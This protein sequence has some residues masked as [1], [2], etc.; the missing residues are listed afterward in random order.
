MPSAVDI[1]AVFAAVLR[2]LSDT[3]AAVHLTE[4][5]CMVQLVAVLLSTPV[6]PVPTQV[7]NSAAA[8]K[9][10]SGRLN[11]LAFGTIRA[12][13]IACSSSSTPQTSTSTVHYAV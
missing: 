8:A 2:L 9:A 7:E 3:T 4:G 12:I 6:A 10:L 11:H 5:N 1:S 13:C